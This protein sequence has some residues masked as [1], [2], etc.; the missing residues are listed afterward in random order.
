MQR[1][2]STAASRVRR[3]SCAQTQRAD[4]GRARPCVRRALRSEALPAPACC[5]DFLSDSAESGA[6]R[7]QA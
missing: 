5:R 3:I 1:A 4:S 2:A 6:P 7:H